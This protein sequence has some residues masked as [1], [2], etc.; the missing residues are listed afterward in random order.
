MNLE[1]L[2]FDLDG[3]L[4]DAR[5]L[6]YQ[7]LNSALS[8][9][10][11]KYVIKREEHLSF[12]DGLPTR[13]KLNMLTMEKQLPEST[14]D[15]VWKLKQE[16]TI[17][18]LRLL[19][20]N[21]DLISLF[22]KLKSIGYHICV[23]TNSIRETAKTAIHSLGIEPYVDLLI[24]N[25]DVRKS[26]P[27]PLMYL[28]CMAHFGADPK[29]TLIFED[30]HHGREA[31]IRS[32][33]H[34]C[35]ISTI[36]DICE[37]FVFSAIENVEKEG[38]YSV[39]TPWIN[40]KMNV[41]IPAAGAGKR[42]AEAGYTFP[43]PLID[44]LGQPMLKVVH[45][46]LNVQANF[47]FLVQ[48]EHC[49]K[50]T[51]AQMLNLISPGCKI[52]QIDGITEGA[53]CT[54]LLARDL[55]DNDDPLL[56]ANSDQ[57]IDDWNSNEFFYSVSADDVDGGILCFGP[58][59]SPKWSYVRLADDGFIAEVAEKKPISDIANTGIHYW[60]KGSDF[61]RSVEKMIA[62]NDRTNGEFYIAP[63]VNHLIAEGKKFKAITLRNDQMC[64]LGTPEDLNAFLQKKKQ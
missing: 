56:I 57:F 35:P 61:V 21:Q 31:A 12:Y 26:K 48:R 7:A 34:L 11:Q 58:Q 4:L 2:C 27:H 32:G 6:H 60:R 59:C 45:D 14:H 3:V 15:L 47:I 51:M 8:R 5:E 38:K 36:H 19:P 20:Q 13:K 40:K 1:L 37:S 44:V 22:A 50:Y 16:E 9:I 39:K 53:A 29:Q 42:F 33:A 64:G 54:A 17:A 28:K 41:L 46:N 10:D 49:E 63:S 24:S 25:E 55:I 23:C 43:K 62:A 52:V 30:S 18:F